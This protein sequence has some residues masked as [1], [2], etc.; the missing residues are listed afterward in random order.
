MEIIVIRAFSHRIESLIAGVSKETL[1]IHGSF[2]SNW[3]CV[4]RCLIPPSHL[5]V[6]NTHGYNWAGICHYRHTCH[7][8]SVDK[9]FH[10]NLSA[11]YNNRYASHMDLASL[12]WILWWFERKCFSKWVTLLVGVVFLEWSCWRS[13]SSQRWALWSHTYSSHAQCLS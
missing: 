4:M 7:T 6:N 12:R 10:I 8:V 5:L 3:E 11:L 2:F 9:L 1:G 13:V